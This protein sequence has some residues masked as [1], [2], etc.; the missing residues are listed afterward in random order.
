MTCIVGIEEDG[1]VYI[2]GDSLGSNADWH[3]TVRADEKVFRRVQPDTDEPYIFG[4]TTS[5]R[6]GQLLRY[7]L[8]IP[9]RHTKVDIF[10]YLATDFIDACRTTWKDGGFGKIENGEEIGGTFLLGY[11]GKLYTI[12]CDNQISR[13]VLT[14]AACGCGE[15]YALG[16]LYG[17]SSIGTLAPKERITKALEAATMHSAGVGS[18]YHI[19]SLH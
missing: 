1:N 15:Y 19:V 7:S 17:L 18:P 9:A 5:F 8:S 6:M 12:Q 3:K 4:F 2:G 10:E 11:Q 14:F 13:S 16:C